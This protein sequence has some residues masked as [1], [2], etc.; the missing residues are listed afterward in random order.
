MWSEI[1]GAGLT[2]RPSGT[3][4]RR[5]PHLPAFRYRLAAPA[6]STGPRWRCCPWRGGGPEGATTAEAAPAA[7]AA[8]TADVPA[9]PAPAEA[10]ET[11][12]CP[13]AADPCSPPNPPPEG[14]SDAPARE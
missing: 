11:A 4:L 9:E 6:S 14:R 12:Q 8:P 10:S 3:A 13:A 7:V 2:C 5:R 1:V